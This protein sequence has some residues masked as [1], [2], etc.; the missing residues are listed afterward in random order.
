MTLNSLSQW[1]TGLWTFTFY[2]PEDPSSCTWSQG[3]HWQP[4][5]HLGIDTYCTK[6]EFTCIYAHI[7]WANHYQMNETIHTTWSTD[8]TSLK[9]S[10]AQYLLYDPHKPLGPLIINGSGRAKLGL[11]HPILA[12]FLCPPD[13]LKDYDRDSDAWVLELYCIIVTHI[14][15]N[16]LGFASYLNVARYLWV[17]QTYLPFSGVVTLIR[18]MTGQ[19]KTWL[20]GLSE[21]MSSSK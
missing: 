2:L 7:Y 11:K 21:A 9:K 12:C 13:R 3:N 16:I 10:I 14:Y 5:V 8:L 19:R 4:K 15:K 17:Q 18:V 20:E 1:Q 6:G